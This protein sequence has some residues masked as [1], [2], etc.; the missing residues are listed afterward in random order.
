MDTLVWIVFGFARRENISL[1]LFD[2]WDNRQLDA[3]KSAF[4]KLASQSKHDIGINPTQRARL[5]SIQTVH[6]FDELYRIFN[7]NYTI[8][9]EGSL[10]GYPDASYNLITSFHVMEHINKNSIE[11]SIEHMFRI[12]KPG[13]FCIHQIGI[14]DHLAHY[15]N[16]VSQKNYLQFS[17]FNRKY[18]FENIVQY[19]NVLQGE[20]YQHLFRKMAS[21]LP[22]S[23]V[24]IVTFP[25]SEF[26][27]TGKIIHKKISKPLFLRSSVINR[28]D[29]T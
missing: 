11:E 13:G 22:K 21:R 8:N 20:D 23:I 12:L 18:L 5:T 19:H 27:P 24:S 4:N 7:A 10:S 14:D 1:E 25:G 16:K 26:I 2:V 15:D 28:Y 29:F 9:S 17:I 3:L 6:S